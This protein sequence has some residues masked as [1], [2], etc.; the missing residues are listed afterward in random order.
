MKQLKIVLLILLAFPLWAQSQLHFGVRGGYSISSV[1]LVPNLKQ[2]SLYDR[3]LD[4]GLVA[5][6]YD[7]QYFGF[8]TELNLTQR[9]YRKP[10]DD[11]YRYKRISTYAE[12]PLFMQIRAKYNN[13]FAHV[14]IGVTMS[15]MLN[16]YHGT[17]T[18]GV[19]VLYKYDLNVLRDNRFDY[20]LMGG[21]GVGYDFKFGTL[22]VE[23]RYHYGFG[24]LYYY[25]FQG[26][27]TRSPARVQNI[28]FTYL[29][30][31]T[32]LFD[33]FTHSKQEENSRKAPNLKKQ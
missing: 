25:N 5:K 28:S 27:P 15:Y 7:L 21:V 31:L 29:Y 18:L 14:N 8:Q 33:K 32:S 17:D 20:G 26:N 4:V 19:Y 30:N 1:D 6:Y 11:E 22:Q 12:V 13:L 16:S 24:D 9:G 10:V 23:A 2:R 3:A